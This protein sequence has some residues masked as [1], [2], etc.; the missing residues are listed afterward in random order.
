MMKLYTMML[1]KDATM[2]EINP[3]VE[4][5]D[6]SGQKKGKCIHIS[7]HLQSRDSNNCLFHSG[8]HGCQGEL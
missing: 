5:Q 6:T 8:V 2:V 4:V 3:L 7:P 1:E